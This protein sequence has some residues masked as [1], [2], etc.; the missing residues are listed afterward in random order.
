[1]N[2]AFN[3]IEISF[4]TNEV[5]VMTEDNLNDRIKVEPRIMQ[6]LY[7]LMNNSPNVVSREK[8]ITEVWD[9]YGGA[10]DALNQ[11]ISHLRK[12]LNDTNRDNRIIET[13]VKKG[14]RFLG[15]NT[16]I[17]HRKRNFFSRQNNSKLWTPIIII[18]TLLLI[19]ISIVYYINSQTSN[20]PIAPVD[21]NTNVSP[22]APLDE[23]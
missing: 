5:I 11:A 19:I 9:N 13:V 23:I 16:K 7:I 20:T 21:K 18:I 3:N 8:L 22:S 17:N 6:V 14:Y 12:L 4:E 10:D 15:D 1:M 2:K